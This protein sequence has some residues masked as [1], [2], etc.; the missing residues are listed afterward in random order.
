MRSNSSSNVF[1]HLGPNEPGHI[2]AACQ[3]PSA[4]EYVVPPTCTEHLAL[5]L[6]ANFLVSEMIVLVTRV[7]TA[8]KQAHACT[9]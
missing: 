4:V 3:K 6:D 5:S 2:R 7:R 1:G 9:V 8:M